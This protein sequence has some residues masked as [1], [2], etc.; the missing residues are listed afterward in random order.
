MLPLLSKFVGFFDRK[1]YIF[2]SIGLPGK[3]GLFQPE[4]M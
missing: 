1:H 4:K 2:V 3:V